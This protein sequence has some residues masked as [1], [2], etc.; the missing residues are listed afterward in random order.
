[1]VTLPGMI[2]LVIALHPAKASDPIVVTPTGTTTLC[3]PAR[4]WN[5]FAPM[6]VTG[7]PS[8]VDGI[9]TLAAVPEYRV[10][11]T[12]LPETVYSKSPDTA[13][14]SS[15]APHSSTARTARSPER[16]RAALVH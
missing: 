1:M 15:P 2:T 3:K 8:I 14:I 12:S 11:L 16:A 10:M 4:P 13:A 7:L 9:T 6:E 5:A